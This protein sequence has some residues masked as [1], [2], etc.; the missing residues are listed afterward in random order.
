MSHWSF[1]ASVPVVLLGLAIC[2]SAWAETSNGNNF[3]LAYL[4]A[5]TPGQKQAILSEAQG[6]PHFFRYLQIME[7]EPVTKDGRDGVRITAFEPSS[8]LDVK[9]TVTMPVSLGELSPRASK[10]RTSAA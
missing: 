9:F 8:C 4:E 10:R 5:K 6:Q 7:L 3:A 2:S 1:A